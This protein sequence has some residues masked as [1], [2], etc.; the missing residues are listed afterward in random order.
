MNYGY[1]YGGNGY[2]GGYW[3]N[4]AF[5]YN[6]SVNNVNGANIHNVYNKTV[7]NHSNNRVSYNGGRGGISVRPTAAQETVSP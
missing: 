4:G 7:I 6:R 3:R 1:G 5:N 2:Q